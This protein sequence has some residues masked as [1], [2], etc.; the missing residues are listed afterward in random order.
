MGYHPYITNDDE[1][2][3]MGR[4]SMVS[5]I[6]VVITVILDFEDIPEGSSFNALELNYMLPIAALAAFV[7][8]T[9]HPSG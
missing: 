8:T 5:S 1:N 6:P 2:L 7:F 3:A 4:G 9:P